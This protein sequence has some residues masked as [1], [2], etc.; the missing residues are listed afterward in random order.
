MRVKA[1][2][3]TE[4]EQEARWQCEGCGKWIRLT[5]ILM[6]KKCRRLLCPNCQG[7][8]NICVACLKQ[9]GF[10]RLAEIRR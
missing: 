3:E 1:K 10:E 6:C 9:L 2:I 7:D 4:T 5:K 8:Q